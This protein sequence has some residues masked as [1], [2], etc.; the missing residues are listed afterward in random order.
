MKKTNAKTLYEVCHF[1]GVII[2]IILVS[3]LMAI[4][5]ICKLITRR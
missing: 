1:F 4:M 3:P 5:M 2:G